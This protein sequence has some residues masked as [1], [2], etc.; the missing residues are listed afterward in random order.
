[1]TWAVSSISR[2]CLRGLDC[3]S[4]LAA[5]VVGYYGRGGGHRGQ[6]EKCGEGEAEAVGG[7]AVGQ[8]GV[9]VGGAKP[10]PQRCRHRQRRPAGGQSAGDPGAGVAA[11]DPERSWS[12]RVGTAQPD[13]RR[14]HDQVGQGQQR[15]RQRQ[16]DAEVAG[17]VVAGHRERGQRGR[18][19]DQP[20]GDRGPQRGPGPG[21]HPAKRAG[22]DSVEAG[23]SL[24]AGDRHDPGEAVGHQHPHERD[25]GQSTDQARPAAV[26]DEHRG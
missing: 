18:G 12:L 5:A 19:G 17:V 25:R 10:R 14:E 7:E 15:H 3:G 4:F 9:G 21:R 24:G 8:V 16:D 23:R 6:W 1:M 22:A 20:A 2:C 13:Q 11:G 26:D